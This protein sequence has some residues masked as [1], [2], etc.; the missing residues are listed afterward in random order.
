MWSVFQAI[1]RSWSQHFVGQSSSF[2]IMSMTFSAMIFVTLALTNIQTL[3][4][5]WGQASQVSIYLKTGTKSEVQ[6]QISMFLKE[7]EIVKDY[8]VVDSKESAA[9]FEKKFTK[10]S[11][12]KLEVAEIHKFF[13]EFFSVQ[14]NQTIAY[15]SSFG[16]LESFAKGIQAKFKEIKSVSYGKR[17][18]DRYVSILSMTEWV[19]YFLTTLFFI[20]AMIVSSSVVKTIIFARR[21]EIEIMEFIGADDLSIYL[22]QVVNGML[23]TGSSFLLGLG[24]NYGL[25]MKVS[26]TPSSLLSQATLAKLHFLS[27]VLIFGMFVVAILAVTLFS[28]VTIFNLMPRRKKAV[29]LRG[30]SR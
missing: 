2:V 11:S 23:L 29:L 3:F 30:L 1:K 12:E 21:D 6:K 17:W 22:P 18:L 24:L 28:L 16:G 7:H 20:A 15:K 26:T 10:I 27:P 14:L 19:A 5:V 13:P 9:N 4:S 8:R 25:F